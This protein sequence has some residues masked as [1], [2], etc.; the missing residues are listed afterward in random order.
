MDDINEVVKF[1]GAVAPLLLP[2]LAKY[3]RA[4]LRLKRKKRMQPLLDAEM[5]LTVHSS[6]LR[7]WAANGHQRHGCGSQAGYAALAGCLWSRMAGNAT[8]PSASPC[9][10]FICILFSY[11]G[12][13]IASS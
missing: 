7:L 3:F 9:N 5:L 10:G 12:A 4:R 8:V 2:P 6:I 13:G 1:L 11:I